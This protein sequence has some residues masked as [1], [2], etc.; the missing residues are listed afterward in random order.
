MIGKGNFRNIGA[1]GQNI[2][3]QYVLVANRLTAIK[4]H[5]ASTQVIVILPVMFAPPR[6]Y[7]D[8]ADQV[9]DQDKEEHCQQ[10]RRERPVLFADSLFY[11]PFVDEHDSHFHQSRKSAGCLVG[12]LFIPACRPE[13]D[14]KQDAATE[15]QSANVFGQRKVQGLNLFSFAVFFD[16]FAGMFPF[17]CNVI[18]MVYIAMMQMRGEEQIPAPLL[19]FHQD[20]QGG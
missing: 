16:Y 18:V 2:S 13:H 19:A 7:R 14:K 11:H 1:F 4:V 3:F 9:V 20:G 5:A 10:V 8:N 15:Q 6:E 12:M 17:A